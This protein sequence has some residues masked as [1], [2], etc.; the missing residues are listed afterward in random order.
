MSK[1]DIDKV[2]GDGTNKISKRMDKNFGKYWSWSKLA[3]GWDMPKDFRK[4]FDGKSN[5]IF[6]R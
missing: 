2:W 5:K 3:G 1:Y 4:A 6:G